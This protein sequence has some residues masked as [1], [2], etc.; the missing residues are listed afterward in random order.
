MK[1][2]ASRWSPCAAATICLASVSLFIVAGILSLAMS[3]TRLN[4]FLVVSGIVEPFCDDGW[5]LSVWIKFDAPDA[6]SVQFDLRR[7]VVCGFARRAEFGCSTVGID[8]DVS[9]EFVSHIRALPRLLA[10]CRP[11]LR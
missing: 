6:H 11:L 5:V 3:Y 10:S 8:V 7:R 1:S 2:Y 9:V 4:S